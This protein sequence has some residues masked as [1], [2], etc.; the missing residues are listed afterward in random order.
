VGDFSSPIFYEKNLP[1][2]GFR[3]NEMRQIFADKF[4]IRKFCFERL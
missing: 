1:V 2:Y 3:E 4:N